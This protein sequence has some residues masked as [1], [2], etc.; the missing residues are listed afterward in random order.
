MRT[1]VDISFQ[2]TIKSPTIDGASIYFKPKS[3]TKAGN[4][5]S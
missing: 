2:D 4:K 5:I 3:T 1:V